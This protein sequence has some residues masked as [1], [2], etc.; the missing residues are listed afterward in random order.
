MKSALLVCLIALAAA[1]SAL[2]E[3]A[4][5]DLWPGKYVRLPK[6]EVGRDTKFGYAFITKEGASYRLD[7]LPEV[8]FGET[9]PGKLLSA[10]EDST[11][12]ETTC[13]LGT[14]TLQDA[15]VLQIV[16]EVR[17]RGEHFY[18]VRAEPLKKKE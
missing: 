18:L 16:I 8:E 11:G 3:E 1:G 10:L 5:R 2:G 6:P 9:H 4:A 12:E 7:A 14:A 17:S 15:G 13:S